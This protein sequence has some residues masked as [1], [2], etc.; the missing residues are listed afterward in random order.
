[1][2]NKLKTILLS[3]AAAVIIFLAYRLLFIRT[4]NYEIAGVKIPSRY[5][6]ITGKVR[7]ILNYH[8]RTIKRTVE[9]RRAGNIGLSEEE[10]VAA[11]IRWAVF[12]EWANSRPEYKGWD[13]N[14]ETFKKAYDAFRKELKN[15]GI[16][17]DRV[18]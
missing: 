18:K 13:T 1:M 3:I 12:E 8:G 17:L 14:A 5:N 9:D 15:Y 2:N 6:I 10:V 4:V 11:Q 7:P 16:G